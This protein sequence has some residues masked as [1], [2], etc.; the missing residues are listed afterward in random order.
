MQGARNLTDECLWFLRKCNIDIKRREETLTST[1]R[2]ISNGM[3][4]KHTQNHWAEGVTSVWQLISVVMA[5][6]GCWLLSANS[7]TIDS[8]SLLSSRVGVRERHTSAYLAA[9]CLSLTLNVFSDCGTII[10]RSACRAFVIPLVIYRTSSKLETFNVKSFRTQGVYKYYWEI[11]VRIHYIFSWKVVLYTHLYSYT[12]ARW[13]GTKT[14]QWTTPIFLT[15]QE[16]K[17]LCVFILWSQ[18]SVLSYYNADVPR[19]QPHR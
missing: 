10:F 9:S 16:R 12:K 6:S 1:T 8:A 11:P 2:T 19:L 13:C 15:S 3:T 7:K 18:M 4:C 5:G 14:P 17:S